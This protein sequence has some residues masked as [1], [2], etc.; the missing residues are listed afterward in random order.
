VNEHEGLAAADLDGD[1]KL[2][3]IG[4]GRWFKHRGGFDFVEN[5]IDASYAF[6][7]AAAGDLKEGGRPEVV[8]VVGDGKGPVVWHEWEKGAWVPN[9]LFEV[10]N[11]HSLQILDFDGDNNLDIFVAEMRLEGHDAA[12]AWF[13]LGD[14]RGNFRASV[15]TTGFEHH[16]SRV[17]DLNGDRLL[18]LLGKPYS[19]DT[20]RLDVWL[21][22]R[23]KGVG[24]G[25]QQEKDQ[26]AGK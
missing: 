4:G 7:R 10:S 20:P 8:L 5:V 18:D 11:G 3:L 16:E 25:E 1:G 17:A 26:R 6:T 19:W 24:T 21:Q 2:D 15:I 23:E 12:K 13:L 14:G 22:E 9:E